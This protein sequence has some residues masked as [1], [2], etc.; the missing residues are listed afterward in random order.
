MRTCALKCCARQISSN[1]LLVTSFHAVFH[2]SGVGKSSRVMSRFAPVAATSAKDAG[3][4]N[5]RKAP[6]SSTCTLNRFSRSAPSSSAVDEQLTSSR[7]R[8]LMGTINRKIS[9]VA[10][11]LNLTIFTICL[12]YSGRSLGEGMGGNKPTERPLWPGFGFQ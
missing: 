1:L 6:V 3:S 7:E 2:P 11:I 8:V 5:E 4:E 12:L 9:F 10:E